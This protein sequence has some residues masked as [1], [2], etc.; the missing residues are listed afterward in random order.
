MFAGAAYIG[1]A[2]VPNAADH[3]TY[4]EW[5]QLD[6]RPEN[7][8]LDGV[9]WGERWV[10]SP[11][12]RDA[13]L[14]AT[15]EWSEFH[16]LNSYWLRPPV[17]RSIAEW[18]QLADDSFHWG[19]RP[20]VPI[21]T[22]SFLSF[23]RPVFGLAAPDALVAP[24]VLP[25]RPN[26]GVYLTV[27]RAS[28]VAGADRAILESRYA[29]YRTSGF[30]A[31]V[32]RPGVAGVWAFASAHHLAPA[33]WAKQEGSTAE[34]LPELRV[35]LYFCDGDPLDLAAALS[36]DDLVA[37]GER[38]CEELLFAGPLEAITPWRWDWFDDE[39]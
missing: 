7:L 15:G 39:G 17:E 6:H 25:M 2:S 27:T 34:A 4:N 35:H 24:H 18:T 30:P 32:R 14:V 20:D 21:T 16:Y 28:A 3:R 23:F 36:V 11:H 10:R 9:Y 33:S 26:R 8:A 38:R 37:P 19:R 1:T 13:A 22:R 12:C 29:W 5:H 31:M